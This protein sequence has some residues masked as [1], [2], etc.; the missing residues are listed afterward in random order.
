[1][2]IRK[3]R[4]CN[5]ETNRLSSYN[6]H[7]N[8]KK[9]LKNIENLNFNDDYFSDSIDNNNDLQ[10]KMIDY[11][12]EQNKI[13][14]EFCK[15]EISH[16]KHVKRHHQICKKKI[17]YDLTNASKETLNINEQLIN[18]K[19]EMERKLEEAEQEK[20]ALK[21]K[22][23]SIKEQ[24]EEKLEMKDK[25]KSEMLKMYTEQIKML[26][27]NLN[28]KQLKYNKFNSAFVLGNF[29][30]AYNFEDL[31]A[32]DLTP[33]EIKL[34]SEEDSAIS[35]CY[36]LLKSR[37]VDGIEVS[38]RPV[39]LVDVARKKYLIRTG[40]NWE[41][42]FGGERIIQGVSD[43]IKNVWIGNPLYDTPDMVITKSEK[44]TEF[45]NNSHK[46]LAYLNDH[47]ILKNTIRKLR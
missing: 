28:K 5:Y 40:G 1:M 15:K 14:C 16:K 37:C 24:M 30:E 21:E 46:I 17:E 22:T 7:L 6:K 19:E 13:F 42:D 41:C 20:M 2:K 18:E 8:S 3:C 38:K 36:K 11:I 33:D 4:V 43:K 29:T 25:E 44:I 32:P 39:H 10:Q 34:L 47:L 9:H 27:G 23:K 12:E 26:L 45:F 31:M 35:G